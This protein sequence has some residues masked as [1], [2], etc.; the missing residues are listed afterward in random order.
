MDPQQ[1]DA[2][3]IGSGLGGLTAG[4]LYA[5][6][7]R[8]VL[9][10]ERNAAFGGAAT[11]YRHGA[12]TIEGS[13]H[14]TAHPR[15]ARDPKTRILEALGILDELEFV[16]IDELYEVRGGPFERP[17]VLPHGLDA[18]RAALGERFPEQRRGFARL[19]ERIDAVQDALAAVG[20]E[21]DRIWWFLHAPA[22]P[23]K[24]WPLLRGLRRTLADVLDALF[25]DAEAAKLAVA[26]N[27]PYYADD[28]ARLWWLY[29]AIAQGGYLASG[30][31]YIRGGSAML[32]GRL[33]AAI[34]E[35]GGRALAGR[36]VTQIELDGRGR[37][38]G[39]VHVDSQGG[40]AREATAPVLFGNAAPAVLAAALPDG[41]RREFTEPYAGRRPSI[42][43]FSVALGLDRSP[44]E[45]GLTRY[46]TVLLPDWM[47]RL[48][49][50]A[51]AAAL[52]GGP[53][54]HRMPP[55]NIVDYGAIDSGLNP[56]GPRLL[57]VVGV[58]R[59][60]HWEGLDEAAYRERRERWQDAIVAAL[61]REFPGLASAVVQR[62][63]ATARTM[64][65]YLNT[66]HGALYGFAPEPPTGLPSVGTEH[67][68]RTSI[69]GLWLASAWGGLGGF[70]GAMATGA[71][72]ARGALG[73][74][75]G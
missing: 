18:A 67:A 60:A 44:A 71:L 32:A 74:R 64:R 38:A 31:A 46:S 39:V 4:A 40:D 73:E 65:N 43:L 20:E 19:F 5:R 66:P 56:D 21:H 47:T 13:L 54:G 63:M 15:D 35:E 10:L 26:A 9:V 59:L 51:D 6:A 49:D 25:G 50:Y 7:G 68:A 2:I 37:A 53:P 12:L 30:G 48:G 72:A 52:L 11:T 3:V 33:V 62:E 45:F 34:E 1:Y 14:A 28:P 17:F 42:S 22:L 61:D 75:A 36:T 29:Y 69:P 27:L 70:S 41:A 8:R 57:T 24:L 23:L 58:D 16:P 55:L